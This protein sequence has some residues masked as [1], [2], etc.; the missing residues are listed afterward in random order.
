MS[1]MQVVSFPSEVHTLARA[2]P[3]E[4]RWYA[5][6]SCANHEKRV[7]R[8]LE[9]RSLESFLPLY[10]RPSR[11]KDRTVKLQLPLFP[12][13]LF[14]RLAI[15]EKLRVLEVPGVVRLVG[16][17]GHPVPLPDEEM[18]AL[19]EG[20]SGSL[21]AEPC[22]YLQVGRRVRVR[23]G[24]LQGLEGIL[25]KKKSGY[26]FVLSLELIQRSIAVEVDAADLE[27]A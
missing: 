10:E 25:L 5:T 4:L 19:R 6:Y 27:G 21:H 23:S 16:F 13:Y 7:A 24:P 20:L 14:V 2:N 18:Q 17:N 11:W 9:L 3:S 26:R 15:E 22:P 12:G 8:Q 1:D